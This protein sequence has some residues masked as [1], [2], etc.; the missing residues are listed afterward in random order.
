MRK[1]AVSAVVCSVLLFSLNALRASGP[2]GV[3]GIVDKAVFE[4]NEA[5]PQRIQVWGVFSVAPY[6]ASGSPII[7]APKRGYLYY[8]PPPAP[9]RRWRSGVA[10]VPP[11]TSACGRPQ[12]LPACRRTTY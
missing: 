5:A 1:L 10:G 3:Y 8:K 4:P 2:L 9:V 12:R 6:S 7:A 11:P